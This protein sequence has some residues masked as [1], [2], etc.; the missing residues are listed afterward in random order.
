ME[1][2]NITAGDNLKVAE[3]RQLAF[4][5]RKA[6]FTYNEIAEKVKEELGIE[7][8]PDHWSGWAAHKD[9]QHLLDQLREQVAESTADVIALEN[10]RLDF[11]LSRLWPKIEA[12]DTSAV[13]A[14]LKIME[15]RSKM[16]G[17]DEAIK[18][19][20]RIEIGGL[21][22]SG[23]ISRQEARLELGD[24][25]YSM[26]AQYLQD[27]NE[28]DL[29]QEDMLATKIRHTQMAKESQAKRESIE[30]PQI[31]DKATVKGLIDLD[32]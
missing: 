1:Y 29:G 21:I 2:W 8:L 17:L 20:W 6:G 15:R 5:L 16:F 26:V 18:H 7:N 31:E 28:I 4:N 32:D 23:L 27:E 19:D 9:I 25:L 11:M 3:R 12:G 30:L 10:N 13:N 22:M 14:A 24:E